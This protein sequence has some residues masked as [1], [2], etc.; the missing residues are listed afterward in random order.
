M[1]YSII[2]TEQGAN[3]G[4]GYYTEYLCESAEDIA[5]L[6]TEVENGGPRPGSLAFIEDDSSAR[7]I[8]KISKEWGEYPMAG[9][10]GGGDDGIVRITLADTSMPSAGGVES[11][12]VHDENG[13]MQNYQTI[14]YNGD[15]STL[16]S[17]DN[18]KWLAYEDITEDASALI[19][20]TS[21]IYS[22]AVPVQDLSMVSD[23]ELC[24]TE[25]TP[26]VMLGTPLDIALIPKDTGLTPG[27]GK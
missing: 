6:P 22:T 25:E 26:V 21:V 14:I 5:T 16:G 8:L 3:A 13:L 1:A 12:Y 20:A 17:F 11:N 2:K 23:I 27:T 10:G 24:L 4:N 15:F 18:F 7:Y 9:G 19:V